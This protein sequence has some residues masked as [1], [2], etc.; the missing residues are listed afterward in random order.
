[1]NAV[2]FE[3]LLMRQWAKNAVGN[4]RTANSSLCDFD[5]QRRDRW[6]IRAGES[7]AKAKECRDAA[8]ALELGGV[9]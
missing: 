8:R 5:Q 1:M 3:R 6:L 7:L 2:Q 9:A 4:I